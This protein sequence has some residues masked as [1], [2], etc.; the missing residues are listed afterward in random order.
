MTLLFLI[1][2][3]LGLLGVLQTIL[4]R[5]FGE[6]FSFREAVWVNGFF[7][8]ASATVYLD[9]GVMAKS[10]D[11]VD[12]PYRVLKDFKFWYCLPGILGFVLVFGFPWAASQIGATRV[13]VAAV[14]G[15]LIAD[16]GFDWISENQRPE[17]L[18]IIG[19]CLALAGAFV[20][21]LKTLKG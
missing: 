19:V 7:V 21:N 14:S 3:T 18:R 10:P 2:F 13:F 9:Y 1:P 17:W 4:N 8:F 12:A 5:S 20:A 11:L 15:Q 6:Q 16:L